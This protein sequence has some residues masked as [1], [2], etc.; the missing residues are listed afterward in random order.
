[1]ADE[2]KVYISIYGGTTFESYVMPDSKIEDYFRSSRIQPRISICVF[3]SQNN[4]ST[5]LKVEKD[6][7]QLLIAL[8][9]NNNVNIDFIYYV[10]K[11]KKEF[12][13]IDVKN[14]ERK[15]FIVYKSN[16]P[17][18]YKRSIW[19]IEMDEK[20]EIKIDTNDI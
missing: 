3:V 4:K 16:Y 14:E 19:S 15:D 11:S 20:F 2:Y 1:M 10:T 9:E 5:E 18:V 6:M 8:K 12:G 13:Y 7:D 17:E